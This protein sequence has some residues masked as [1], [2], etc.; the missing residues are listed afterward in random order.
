MLALQIDE[1]PVE[2]RRSETV[3]MSPGLSGPSSHQGGLGQ[4]PN[5]W[6]I[7]SR[8][9]SRCFGVSNS[10]RFIIMRWRHGDPNG[11]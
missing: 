3:A 11:R 10:Q 9:F 5:L 1:C 2:S 4:S 8:S 7:S 6:R